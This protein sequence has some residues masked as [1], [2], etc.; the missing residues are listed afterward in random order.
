MTTMDGLSDGPTVHLVIAISTIAFDERG[1]VVETVDYFSDGSPDWSAA[2]ICDYRGCGGKEGYDALRTALFA[3]EKNARMCGY[4][5]RRV[6]V[7]K[8]EP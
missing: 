5:I 8:E 2:G 3:A 4:E 7:P 1:E 6:P